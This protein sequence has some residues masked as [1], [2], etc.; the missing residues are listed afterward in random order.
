M[1][2]VVDSTVSGPA[3]PA[4]YLVQRD[5]GFAIYARPSVAKGFVQFDGLCRMTEEAALEVWRRLMVSRM[6]V[7]KHRT[8]RGVENRAR[9]IARRCHRTIHST[10]IK[11]VI[12]A[13]VH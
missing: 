9:V 6:Y 7:S 13:A 3:G 2:M 10:Q 8:M 5:D 1:P 12:H 4:L 11:E